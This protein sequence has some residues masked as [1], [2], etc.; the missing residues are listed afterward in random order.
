M[1][2]PFHLSLPVI[3]VTCNLRRWSAPGILLYST[4]L[5]LGRKDF[6]DCLQIANCLNAI[7]K[8]KK[9]EIFNSLTFIGNPTD[10]MDLGL[11]IPI[12]H[13]FLGI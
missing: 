2:F 3:S 5:I 9:K 4:L 12:F 8:K 6:S 10:M 7:M 1:P 13:L 11:V